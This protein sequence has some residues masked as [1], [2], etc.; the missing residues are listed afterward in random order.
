MVTIFLLSLV[1]SAAEIDSNLYVNILCPAKR[2]TIRMKALKPIYICQLFT[3]FRL[4]SKTTEFEPSNCYIDVIIPRF[5]Y[6]VL[7]T[8]GTEHIRT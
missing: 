2:K 6:S 1:I 7:F 5:H 3:D 4:V 8:S